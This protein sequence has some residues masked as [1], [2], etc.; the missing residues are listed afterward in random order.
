MEEQKKD[1]KKKKKSGKWLTIFIIIGV[2]FISFC[3]G[4]VGGKFFKPML[5]PIIKDMPLG[6]FVFYVCLIYLIFIG[7]AYVHIIVHEAGHL[8]SGLLTGYQFSSFRIGSLMWV[9]TEGKLKFKRFSLAGTGGQCLM[10][11]PDMVDGKIPYVLYNL[12]GSLANAIVSVI[13]ALFVL[14]FWTPGFA[15]FM[16]LVWSFVGVFIALSNGIPMRIQGSDNDGNNAKNLGKNPEALKA[17]WLQMKINEKVANGAM[18]K[19]LPEEWFE[20]PSDEGLKNPLI[21][22]IAVFHCSRLMELGNY[23]EA[24]T[25]IEELLNKKTGIAGV[26]RNLLLNDQIYCELVGQNRKERLENLYTD[27]QKKF[28]K[29]MK[30]APSVLRT[31]YLCERFIEQDEKKAEA[32]LKAFE[33]TVKTYPYAHEVASER[34]MIE[35]AVSVQET[36]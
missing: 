21:A 1:E 9:K 26:H 20:M 22:A 11:P 7:S 30:L 10:T 36:K 24:D 8:I 25:E 27:E 6:Q 16:I 15:N 33:N 2:I 13:P 5:Q 29:S 23:E 14:L 3:I 12:G 31:Q 28:M 4:I 32:T 35:Y 34:A 19:D 17:F 18:T